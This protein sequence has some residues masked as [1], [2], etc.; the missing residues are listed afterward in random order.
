IHPLVCN[1]RG[2]GLAG[3][4]PD[5]QFLCQILYARFR[6][7]EITCPTRYA[8]DSSSISFSNSV[9]YGL[10][11]LRTTLDMVLHTLGWRKNALFAPLDRLRTANTRRT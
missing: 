11:V 5:N 6:I 2:S 1:R 9:G 10:A 4:T 7:G 3:A 8:A